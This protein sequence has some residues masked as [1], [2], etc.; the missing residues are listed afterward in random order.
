LATNIKFSFV[1]EG[2]NLV[3]AP[4]TIKGNNSGLTIYLSEEGEFV[5]ILEA[6][7][8]K[9][10]ESG[11]FF[12][13]ATVSVQ[14]GRRE[15]SWMELSSLVGELEGAGLEVRIGGGEVKR[16]PA[17]ARP[18]EE[19]K[20]TT[21]QLVKGTLRSGQRIH[22]DGNVVILGDV[23]PGAEVVATGDIIV[24]G[25]CR[26]VCHAGA[27]GNTTSS[28]LALRLKPTQLRIAD[29]IARSPDNEVHDSGVPEVARMKNNT[30]VIETYSSE[31]MAR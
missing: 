30:V 25:A 22:Y 17:S 1:M 24:L 18:S 20:E 10:R 27:K 6:L 31:I 9:L 16:K 12:A 4:L 15:L 23:N 13:G 3:K 11:A 14:L 26:G 29:F 21:T 8:D 19:A 28:V 7:R 5:Q 2:K